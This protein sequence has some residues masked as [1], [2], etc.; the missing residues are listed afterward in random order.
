MSRFRVL[1]GVI[2]LFFI[3]ASVLTSLC[4]YNV[5][6]ELLCILQKSASSVVF[7]LGE[8]QYHGVRR[9]EDADEPLQ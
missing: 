7:V 5:A 2:P 6:R 3:A 9:E 4:L 1:F 8:A